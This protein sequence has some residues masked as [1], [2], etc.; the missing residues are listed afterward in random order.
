MAFRIGWFYV[1]DHNC[2]NEV[3]TRLRQQP[4]NDARI[5]TVRSVH[6]GNSK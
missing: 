6:W 1:C 4:E 5:S 2:S 3:T